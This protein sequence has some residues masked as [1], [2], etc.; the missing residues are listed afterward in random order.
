MFLRTGR[1][2]RDIVTI[3]VKLSIKPD[4]ILRSVEQVRA[5]IPLLTNAMEVKH[6]PLQTFEVLQ[7][8]V[9]H[10]TGHCEKIW[11]MASTLLEELHLQRRE[12]EKRQ[13]V[14]GL[15]TLGSFV[16]GA[17]FAKLTTNDQSP[18]LE[19]WVDLTTGKVEAN[20][21]VLNKVQ[22]FIE[23]EIP[24]Q[25]ATELDNEKLLQFS[26]ITSQIRDLLETIENEIQDLR[27]GLE[28]AL[29]GHLSQNLFSLNETAHL[30][31]L[32]KK[33]IP[34]PLK[35]VVQANNLIEFYKLPVSL[36]FQGNGEIQIRMTIPAY[37]P[38]TL[39]DLFHYIPVPLW[40]DEHATTM[41]IKSYYT[42]LAINRDRTLHFDL[43]A[44]HL[45]DCVLLNHLYF[46]PHLLISYKKDSCLSALFFNKPEGIRELCDVH[47]EFG[48]GLRAYFLKD[49]WYSIITPHRTTVRIDCDNNSTDTLCLPGITKVE[50][51]EGCSLTSDAIHIAPRLRHIGLTL[52]APIP[53]HSLSS[54]STEL[55]NLT[56]FLT[57]LD[58]LSH[59]E[60][61]R[62]VI[63]RLK[64]S[65]RTREVSLENILNA[66]A[67]VHKE[68]HPLWTFSS[69][70][71][72]STSS[73]IFCLLVIFLCYRW[74]IY[75]RTDHANITEM[76]T[77]FR[78]WQRV[79][80]LTANEIP[81]IH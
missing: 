32:L 46:C 10:L 25:F 4:T 77:A 47:L 79:Y 51:P 9:A 55:S 38:H 37:N 27:V 41:M 70:G 66:A 53:T 15:V 81:A 61:V 50:I 22:H 5:L 73:L 56:Y 19:H 78:R 60:S 52:T 36:S 62:K 65:S 69:L 7:T 34:K 33:G 71:L 72:A 16:S 48:Q 45:S 39:Y 58:E 43:V 67:R 75:R 29:H 21:K 57:H 3:N 30:F 59:E 63:A 12:R 20:S 31:Q 11:S 14:A 64:A 18:A 8:S 17:L 13:V 6:V 2:A 49:G 74:R 44:A 23:N 28:M 24:K 26:L 68:L 40:S 1:V 54:F 76:Q 35:L 42:H 80:D